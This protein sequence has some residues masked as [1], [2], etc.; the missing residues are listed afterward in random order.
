MVRTEKSWGVYWQSHCCCL[1][2]FFNYVVFVSW[3]TWKI[4]SYFYLLYIQLVSSDTI[5]FAN[6]RLFRHIYPIETLFVFNQLSSNPSIYSSSFR[7]IS[8]CWWMLAVVVNFINCLRTAT[9]VVEIIKVISFNPTEVIKSS[10]S[11]ITPTF[12]SQN[13]DSLFTPLKAKHLTLNCLNL[14]FYSSF[15][16]CFYLDFFLEL[17]AYHR[18]NQI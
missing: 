8:C 4:I 13:I 17:L 6:K 1:V 9:V 14:T 18:W 7:R 5:L 12:S 10:Y 2:D 3:I 15:L 11:S 16:Y